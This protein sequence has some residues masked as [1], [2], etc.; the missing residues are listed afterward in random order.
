MLRAVNLG[1]DTDTVASVT[2]GLA[3]VLLGVHSIPSDWRGALARGNDITTLVEHFATVCAR[4]A[5]VWQ[6][7][8]NQLLSPADATTES[9][10][11]K[12]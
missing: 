2:G 4:E 3:G 7:W 1:G 5:P 12:A 9:E 10:A 8:I 6:A 11:T